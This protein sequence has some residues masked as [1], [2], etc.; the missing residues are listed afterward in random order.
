[1][2][3]NELNAAYAADGYARVRGAGILCTTYGVG[4]L[5]AINGVLGAKA[6][7][8]PV[9]HIVGQPSV[10]LQRRHSSAH[11]TLGDGVFGN[12]R[13][14]S[15][16]GLLPL[17]GAEGEA[18][19]MDTFLPRLQRFLQPHDVVVAETGYSSSRS[20]PGLAFPEGAVSHNQV[21]WGSIGWATPAAFGAS[22]ADT[23][24]R[25][26]LVTGDGSHQPTANDIGAMGKHGAS[27]SSS[28]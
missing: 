19:S 7:R 8:L 11:H 22:L 26:I 16:A 4:E 25:T 23:S 27:P 24:R 14:L 1:M 21:L 2:S 17:T 5:S 15:E 12:F 28:S 18:V 10:R 13:G 3:T 9:F 20:V 6:G